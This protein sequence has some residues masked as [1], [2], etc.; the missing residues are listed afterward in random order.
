LNKR[1]VRICGYFQKLIEGKCKR[2]HY[3]VMTTIF[4]LF[5]MTVLLFSLPQMYIKRVTVTGCK[6]LSS[7]Q[8]TTST[9]ILT[10]DHILAHIGGGIVPFFSLR[11][12]NIES[13]L[14]EEYP[15]IQEVTVQADF[16]SAVKITVT[17][18]QKIGYIEIPDGYAVIDKDGYVLEMG[19]TVPADVVLIE[20][21]PAQTVVLGEKLDLTQQTNLNTSILVLQAIVNADANRQGSG[22][23]T[24]MPCVQS[25]QTID[26]GTTFL[27]VMLP[28]TQKVMLVRLGSIS[29]FSDKMDWL[30]YAVSIGSFDQVSDGVLDMTG[31]E[32]TYRSMQ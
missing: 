8:I 31:E 3:V 4:L 23:F 18:R 9:G 28:N 25:V 32:N 7:D 13:E 21:I 24:L 27:S 5:V 20:G 26:S 22:D 14:C 15:Y 2:S 1:Y 6:E 29:S 30:R 10:G 11:Y 16:P 17:E 12:G 19:G